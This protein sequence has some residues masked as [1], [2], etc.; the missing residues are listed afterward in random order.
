MASNP[1]VDPPH[2]FLLVVTELATCHGIQYIAT[3]LL[4]ANY[5]VGVGAR[6]VSI[7]AG[8]L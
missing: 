4:V 3:L 8:V 2:S 7:R 6:N 1:S 5:I